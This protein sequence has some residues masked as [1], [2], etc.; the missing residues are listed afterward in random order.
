MR[1]VDAS[2]GVTCVRR[3]TSRRFRPVTVL[4]RLIMRCTAAFA[5][6]VR[7]ASTNAL[8]NISSAVENGI[9]RATDSTARGSISICNAPISDAWSRETGSAASPVAFDALAFLAVLRVVIGTI[10]EAALQKQ[11][12]VVV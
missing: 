2:A 11:G 3:E 12:G 9:P 6:A 8:F 5:W 4:M 10:Y 7:A 1:R